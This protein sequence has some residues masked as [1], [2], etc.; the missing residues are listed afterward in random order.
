MG[1]KIFEFKGTNILERV[2][3]GNVTKSCK[4]IGE[5]IHIHPWRWVVVVVVESPGRG[6]EEEED[7]ATV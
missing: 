7:A 2:S 3:I 5:R 1:M 4:I 6:K